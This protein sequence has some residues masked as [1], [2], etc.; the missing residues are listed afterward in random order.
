MCSYTED[1][2]KNIC[3]VMRYGG[4]VVLLQALFLSSCFSSALFT[5]CFVRST[6]TLEGNI[7]AHRRNIKGIETKCNVQNLWNEIE[8]KNGQWKNRAEANGNTH[9]SAY[10]TACSV[11]AD[12]MHTLSPTLRCC[13]RRQIQKSNTE[14]GKQTANH[15][16]N[17]NLNE[18]ELYA[19]VIYGHL[20][21]YWK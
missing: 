19:S 14:M 2:E 3:K 6:S 20:L 18:N 10:C 5:R 13:H 8:M 15:G 12:A 9:I 21:K 1:R 17:I 7:T 16:I 4:C 11:C